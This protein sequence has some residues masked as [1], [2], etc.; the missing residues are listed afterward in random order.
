M[1]KS[2]RLFADAH[3]FDGEFQGSRT[4]IKE[5][6]NMLSLKDDL[7][8]YLGAY[9][10][11][12]LSNFFDHKKIR[13]IQY[14]NRSSFSRL[15][16]DIPAIIKEYQIDF[17][18]FQYIVPIKKQCRFIVT[19]HDVIFNDFP[20]EFSFM[21]RQ[22]RNHLYSRGARKADVLTTVSEYSRKAIIKHLQVDPQ[23]VEVIPNAVNDIFFQPYNKQV[24]K[25]F[26]NKKY[27]L[28]KIILYVSRFEPRKNHDQLLRAFVDLK[29]ND[30]GFQ[31]VLIGAKVIP[32]PDFDQILAGLEL[33]LKESV[34][35]FDRIEEKDIIEF[36]RAAEVFVYPSKAEGFGIPPLEAAA[37]R[38]PVICSNNSA[39]KE[40]SFFGE[41]FFNPLD[42]G[43]LKSKLAAVCR[44]GM[45]DTRLESIAQA[46]QEKYSWEKSADRLHQLIRNA[47]LSE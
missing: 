46:V 36:Y 41:C 21:F 37:S 44:A 14:R 19:I 20:Q 13:F 30:Q 25:N 2:I 17:A 22:S 8:I 43:E 6:Y 29:L 28:A 16:R 39:M 38:I 33:S 7:Q 18:H 35:I 11:K 12:N 32:V 34:F 15:L 42:P 47:Y 45:K 23:K 5:I 27:G 40:F 3:V 10:L 9:D 24:S 26:L 31:L 1:E 4:F